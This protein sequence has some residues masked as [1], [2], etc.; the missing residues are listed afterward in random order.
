MQPLA[1]QIE[2]APRRLRA[3]WGQLSPVAVIRVPPGCLALANTRTTGKPPSA[4]TTQRHPRAADC[5]QTAATRQQPWPAPSATMPAGEMPKP[6]RQKKVFK[7][8]SD[9]QVCKAGSA[10]R[11]PGC[12]RLRKVERRVNRGQGRRR[13]RGAPRWIP[14]LDTARRLM[15]HHCTSS[16]APHRC[17]SATP[18]QGGRDYE[19][20]TKRTRRRRGRAR[21]PD[22]GLPT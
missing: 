7:P 20:E 9:A 21:R 19:A 12:A 3:Q 17:R 16:V 18:R 4:Y 1:S 2:T 22:Q 11:V 15:T 14:P 13:R 10:P 5:F 6:R 8:P